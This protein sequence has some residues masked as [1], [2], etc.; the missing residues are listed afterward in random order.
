VTPVGGD[1]TRLSAWMVRYGAGGLL[2]G[3]VVTAAV[4]VAGGGHDSS[5]Q[6]VL[7][8]WAF[9][10]GTYWLTHVYVHAAAALLHGDHRSLLRRSA[11]SARTEVSVLIGGIPGIVVFLVA[12]ATDADTLSAERAALYASVGLLAGVGYIG[13]RGAGRALPAALGEAAAAGMLGVIMVAA[14]TLLH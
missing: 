7:V 5:A 9:V 2:Y 3:A 14:K 10:L 1:R 6:R 13:A 12:S 4:L 8:T 11:T